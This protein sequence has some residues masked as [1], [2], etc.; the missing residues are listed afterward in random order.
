[1]WAFAVSLFAATVSTAAYASERA[2]WEIYPRLVCRFQ[3]VQFCEITFHDCQKTEGTAV[4]TFDFQK[5]TIESF[6]AS[7]PEAIVS[8]NHI[9]MDVGYTREN[10]ALMERYGRLGQFDVNT[11][12]A[13]SGFYSFVKVTKS[14]SPGISDTIDGI[15]QAP[16]GQDIFTAHMLCHPQ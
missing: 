16:S 7:N 14:T 6:A 13:R 2:A 3:E 10:K 11:V 15:A 5:N 1:M 8:K 4:L 9:D 12:L